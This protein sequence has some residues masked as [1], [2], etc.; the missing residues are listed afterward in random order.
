MFCKRLSSDN[1]SV[2]VEILLRSV[3]F[4]KRIAGTVHSTIAIATW[5]SVCVVLSSSR[6]CFGLHQ[7]ADCGASKVVNVMQLLCL[8]S[9]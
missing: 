9:Y 8:E 7:T 4:S 6:S 1:T 2:R 3:F 5:R